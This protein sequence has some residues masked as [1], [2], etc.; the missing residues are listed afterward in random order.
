MA[1]EKIEGKAGKVVLM[2]QNATSSWGGTRKLPYA[3]TEQGIAM[4]SSV[5]KELLKFLA[6]IGFYS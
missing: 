4:L 2:S 6:F 5:L 3:F 1:K